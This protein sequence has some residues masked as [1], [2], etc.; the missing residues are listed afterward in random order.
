LF[1]VGLVDSQLFNLA[2]VRLVDLAGFRVVLCVGRA[3]GWRRLLRAHRLGGLDF[4]QLRI[5]ERHAELGAEAIDLQKVGLLNNERL[6][7]IVF[8]HCS[9]PL[10]KAVV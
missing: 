1:G 6:G 7:H 2:E 10:A 4:L 9:E 5:H 3:F 8:F